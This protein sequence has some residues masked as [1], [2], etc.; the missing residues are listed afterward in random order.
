MGG[1]DGDR[2][3]GAWWEGLRGWE[4]GHRGSRWWEGDV[5]PWG[6]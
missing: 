5:P 6:M 4:G 2:R 1:A 3:G